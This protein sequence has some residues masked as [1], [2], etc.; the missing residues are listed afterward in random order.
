[1]ED[2]YRENKRSPRVRGEDD[3][4]VEL[5]AYIFPSDCTQE[6]RDEGTHDNLCR[7]LCLFGPGDVAGICLFLML[8]AVAVD[9]HNHQVD[10]FFLYRYNHHF[11]TCIGE[12]F[13]SRL[14]HYKSWYTSSVH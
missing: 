12:E 13:N 4:E 10:I 3:A 14:A 6:R 7:A 2:K 5:L 8:S 11:L 1:L 9:D